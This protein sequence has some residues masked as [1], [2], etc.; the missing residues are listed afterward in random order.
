MAHRSDMD[1]QQSR[2]TRVDMDSERVW[3]E[4]EVAGKKDQE[5]GRFFLCGGW[6]CVLHIVEIK[7]GIY[8]AVAEDIL[9]AD[10][11]RKYVLSR[12]NEI[13]DPKAIKYG[14]VQSHLITAELSSDAENLKQAYADKGWVF[15][16]PWD[17]LVER[18]KQTHHQFR[19]IL[20]RKVSEA[21]PNSEE[22][23]EAN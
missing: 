1:A 10:K 3:A 11:Y 4:P 17:D 23:S 21:M 12:F 5:S 9:Q 20:K 6:G 8:V 15:F 7:R 22:E 13:S 19:Q 2:G 14:L 16:R 18:A